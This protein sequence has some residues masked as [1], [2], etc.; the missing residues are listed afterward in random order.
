MKV[1]FSEEVR[2]D[3]DDRLAELVHF[4][5]AN[6]S[7][8]FTFKRYSAKTFY[9]GVAFSFAGRVLPYLAGPSDP[10]KYAISSP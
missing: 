7:E 9:G 1:N 6:F 3:R 2:Y 5:I 10:V 4:L 8:K